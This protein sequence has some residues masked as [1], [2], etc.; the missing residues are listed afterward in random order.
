MTISVLLFGILGLVAAIVI[1]AFRFRGDLNILRSQQQQMTVRLTTLERQ[2]STHQQPP[3][4]AAAVSRSEPEPPET[5]QTASRPTPAPTPAASSVP[6]V[7]PAAPAESQRDLEQ[8]LTQRW[9]VWLGGIILMIG[10]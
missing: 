4:A 2:L 6:K 10:G 8:L 3:T 1:A 5:A 7:R 9:G